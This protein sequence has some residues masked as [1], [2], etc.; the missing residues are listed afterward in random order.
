MPSFAQPWRPQLNWDTPAAEVL[1]RFVDALPSNLPWRVIVFGSSP[2]Q[3]GVDPTFL[4]GDVDV[5]CEQDVTEFCRAA[6]LP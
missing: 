3:L 5:I 4:S 2:L 6:P 1:D